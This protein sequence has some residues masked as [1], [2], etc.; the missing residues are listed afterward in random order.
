MPIRLG[1]LP[2]AYVTKADWQMMQG[3]DLRSRPWLAPDLD[4]GYYHNHWGR[5]ANFLVLVAENHRHIKSS[6]LRR[7]SHTA[8][9][10]LMQGFGV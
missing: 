7:G 4:M 1:G 9:R 6:N 10:E 2:Q 8:R 3:P 5:I